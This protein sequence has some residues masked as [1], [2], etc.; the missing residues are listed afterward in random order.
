M[1]MNMIIDYQTKKNRICF[2]SVLLSV[3]E[4]FFFYLSDDHEL[5]NDSL[6]L[7]IFKNLFRYGRFKC[8]NVFW[9]YWFMFFFC[10]FC[11]FLWSLHSFF[12]FLVLLC[13]NHQTILFGQWT[14]L[15]IMMMFFFGIVKTD[16]H[17]HQTN[18]WKRIFSIKDHSIL[19]PH[20]QYYCYYR[21][22]VC[23]DRFSNSNLNVFFSD[24]QTKKKSNNLSAMKKK[25]F[26]RWWSSLI[27]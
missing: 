13:N 1:N 22:C 15:N 11:C 4:F 20:S 16:H 23:V 6:I 5:M 2:C 24:D 3:P 25:K 14:L 9:I 12:F 7:F 21:V 8:M 10:C 19:L 17:H 26:F 18:K 27:V